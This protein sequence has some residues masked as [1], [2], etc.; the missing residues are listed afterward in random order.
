MWYLDVSSR[1]FYLPTSLLMIASDAQQ[2]L[3]NDASPVYITISPSPRIA[4]AS[5]IVRSEELARG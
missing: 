2:S 1:P 5:K 3:K 4:N